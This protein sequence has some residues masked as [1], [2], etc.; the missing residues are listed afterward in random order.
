[1]MRESKDTSASLLKFW[2][3]EAK[4]SKRL[5]TVCRNCGALKEREEA[6]LLDKVMA[7][8][9]QKNKSTWSGTFNFWWTRSYFWESK[10]I[11]LT[12]KHLI[13]E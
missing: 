12:L 3:F 8:L 11:I 4:P 10:S 1:M 6:Q 13:K 2:N 5:V 7:Y 9:I